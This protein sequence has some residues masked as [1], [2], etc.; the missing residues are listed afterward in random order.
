[1]RVG[2]ERRLS[3][4]ARP[5]VSAPARI[6]RATD[7]ESP[8]SW[9]HPRTRPERQS[10]SGERA[11][12]RDRRVVRGHRRVPRRPAEP[13]LAAQEGLERR[14][15]RRAHRGGAEDLDP[16]R[17]PQLAQQPHGERVGQ[18]VHPVGGVAQLEI[19]E[20]PA[21]RDVERGGRETRRV[22][23][24]PEQA[25]EYH[26]LGARAPAQLGGGGP[27]PPSTPAT[28][29]GGRRHA[30]ERARAVEVPGEHVHQPLAPERESG[31]G[32]IEG[33]D[34]HQVGVERHGAA[35]MPRS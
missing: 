4:A 24:G 7:T 22:S 28:D 30:P 31:V 8:A 14:Q 33:G 20:R 12:E 9:D 26:D 2:R 6:T 16:P 10:G 29:D 1:M 27:I 25:A 19:G 32:H 35:R 21:V 18:A 11:V 23:P 5:W 34:G 13:L 3:R 17:A 15:R